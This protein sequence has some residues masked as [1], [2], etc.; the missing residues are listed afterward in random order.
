MRV[1]YEKEILDLTAQ[2]SVD[3]LLNKKV[4]VFSKR[5]DLIENELIGTINEIDFTNVQPIKPFEILL[6]NQNQNFFYKY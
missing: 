3:L 2:D 1:I 6:L 5:K 4:K